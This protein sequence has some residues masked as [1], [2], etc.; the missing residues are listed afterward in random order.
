M[1]LKKSAL[2]A[3]PKLIDNRKLRCWFL[4]V[5][6]GLQVRCSHCGQPLEGKAGQ[7]FLDFRITTCA[8]CH[9]KVFFFRDTPF[10]AAKVGQAEFVVLA[11]LLSLKVPVRDIAST[12][13]LAE[14][15]VRD[16]AHKLDMPS[17]ATRE[18]EDADTT[19]G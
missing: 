15:T 11:A 12:L 5:F 18:A 17:R 13:N 2:F 16:W 1:D 9:K 19:H 10:H 3:L 6:H 14:A 8:A 4:T 7:T